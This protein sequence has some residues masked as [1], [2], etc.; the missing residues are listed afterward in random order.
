MNQRAPMPK[1]TDVRPIGATLYYLPIKTRVPLKF[2]PEIT[3]ECTCARVQITVS[4]ARG[5]SAQGW[6]ETPLSVQWVWPSALGYE[7]RHQVLKEFTE[8]LADAWARFDVSGHP[9]EVGD[10]FMKDRLP[11]L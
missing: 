4:D 5:R 10:A 3:T 11:A 6:G 7:A 8:R 9:I 2:G 1:S